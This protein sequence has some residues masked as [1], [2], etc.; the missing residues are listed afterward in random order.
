MSVGCDIPV[1]DNASNR[2][3]G[4]RSRHGQR[5]AWFWF[6]C[7]LFSFAISP[8]AFT[9]PETDLNDGIMFL[10]TGDYEA[11][12]AR[13]QA[14][15]KQVPSAPEPYFFAGAALN[16]LGRPRAAIAMFERATF[17][18]DATPA[19][20]AH[21]D[22]DFEF[23]WALLSAGRFDDA[24][25]ALT[26]YERAH[27]GRGQTAEFLGR[28]AV[29]SGDYAAAERWFDEA[30]AR[31]PALAETVGLARA[32]MLEKR[33]DV[34][35]AHHELATL[36]AAEESTRLNRLL[37]ERIQPTAAQQAAN[38]GITLSIGAGHNSNALGLSD[39]QPI[40]TVA[41]AG[42]D[43]FQRFIMSGFYRWTPSD[44]DVTA[45][46]SLQGDKYND[47]TDVNQLDNVASLSIYKPLTERLA[48]T[49][50]VRDRYTRIANDGLLNEIGVTP[51]LAARISDYVLVN[52]AYTFNLGDYLQRS[53]TPMLD[54]D[55]ETH[56]VGPG[57]VWSIPALRSRVIADYTHRWTDADGA[58]F[59]AEGDEFTLRLY[60]ALPWRFNSRVVASFEHRGFDHPNSLSPSGAERDDDF[61][62]VSTYLERPLGDV[63]GLSDRLRV[64]M[65]YDYV[66]RNSN[67]DFYSYHQHVFS[68]GVILSL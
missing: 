46:Y 27:P 41:D 38:Y 13:F 68:A 3:N 23:A 66:D 22:L 48:A 7:A 11:A 65:Q 28:A 45:Q 51:T 44:W 17:L 10:G 31:E 19:V 30:Q 53:A 59:D 47:A 33:G 54:R 18:Y 56:S 9:N 5:R 40:S 62:Y 14:A 50:E 34:D 42:E 1:R 52:V 37:A 16:R 29:G 43:T 20:Q 61:Y 64:Y 21:R 35:G 2:R 60:S 57:V 15:G 24:T 49:V 36:L 26:R 67:I 39:D 63:P 8:P 12:L 25:A 58:D 4:I 32:A 6:A 55:H